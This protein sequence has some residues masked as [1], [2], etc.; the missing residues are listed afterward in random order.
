VLRVG[1]TAI[2][3]PLVLP[4]STTYVTDRLEPAP[5]F[6]DRDTVEPLTLP[7]RLVGAGGATAA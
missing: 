6:H 2:V 3:A 4:D 5:G 1:D 7:V